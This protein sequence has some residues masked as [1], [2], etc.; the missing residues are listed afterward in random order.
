MSRA[1]AFGGIILVGM[2]RTGALGRIILAK[3]C[4]ARGVRA[5]F[6]LN[7]DGFAFQSADYIAIL[8]WPKREIRTRGRHIRIMLSYSHILILSYCYILLL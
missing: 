1:G 8:N 2:S 6:M 4:R 7:I 3:M 5:H